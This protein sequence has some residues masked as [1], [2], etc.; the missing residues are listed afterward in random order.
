MQKK[1]MPPRLFD[2]KEGNLSMEVYLI[3]H[4]ET[5][6]NR[7]KCYQGTLDVPLSE[8]G[9]AKLS[10]ADFVPG[11]VYVTPMCRTQQTAEILFPNVPQIIVPELKEMSFGIFEGH[12]HEEL[13]DDPH[14][15]AWMESE[16]VIPCPEGETRDDFANRT[17]AALGS[18]IDNALEE[19]EE[20]LVIVA[21]GGTQMAALAQLGLPERRS[22]ASWLGSNGGGYVL[23]TARWKSEHKLEVIREVG[24]SSRPCEAIILPK[25]DVKL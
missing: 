3:R 19:G 4:G 12:N 9:K 6:F 7:R 14:Y 10:C 22:Y 1:V 23:S 25:E 8:E 17:C 24:Y 13:K 20:R 16:W 21:H 5:E 2:A 18:L 11:K 15:Q